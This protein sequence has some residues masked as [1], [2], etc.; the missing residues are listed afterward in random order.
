[1]SLINDALKKTQQARASVAGQDSLLEAP[2]GND[3]NIQKPQSSSPWPWIFGMVALIVIAVPVSILAFKSGSEQALDNSPPASKAEPAAPLAP[4]PPEAVEPVPPLPV[5]PT[6]AAEPTIPAETAPPA[7]EPTTVKTQPESPKAAEPP[8]P[9]KN[10]ETQASTPKVIAANPA[11]VNLLK[12]IKVTGIML[13]NEAEERK[14]LLDGRS[15]SEDDIVSA[16]LG[17]RIAEIREKSVVF[18]DESGVRYTK[19][20]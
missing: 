5:T 1:M 15:Y 14:I 8:L 6:K 18:I 16:K 2:S 20:F 12:S 19:R 17:C 13:S 9:V 11:V 7:P 3:A 10:E 4:P